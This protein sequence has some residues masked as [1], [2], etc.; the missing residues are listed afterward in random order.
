MKRYTCF[1]LKNF[2]GIRQKRYTCFKLRRP[3]GLPHKMLSLKVAQKC[4]QLKASFCTEIEAQIVD[5]ASAHIS[6]GTATWTWV[7][8]NNWFKLLW[9]N[10]L[11]PSGCAYHA[12]LPFCLAQ[13][14]SFFNRLL[15]WPLLKEAF[16]VPASL[17]PKAVSV[18][19]QRCYDG[20]ACP[21][22]SVYPLSAQVPVSVRSPSA[23][24]R[25]GPVWPAPRCF[26]RAYLCGAD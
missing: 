23:L 5:W 16:P 1:I 19:R 2:L 20:T 6:H 4:F 12:S 13:G 18:L 9:H 7:W 14:Y 3:Q 22:C 10:G 24:G 21:H 15:Q 11:C 8:F 17:I 25:A 26:F